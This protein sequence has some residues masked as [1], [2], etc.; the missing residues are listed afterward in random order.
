[1]ST[2]TLEYADGEITKNTELDVT[3]TNI[4][5]SW[6][7][8]AVTLAEDWKIYKDD[9]YSIIDS[10]QS[11]STHTSSNENGV[12][13]LKSNVYELPQGAA[14]N[15]T[16]SSNIDL[17][18]EFSKETKGYLILK[19]TKPDGKIAQE[20]IRMS[21]NVNSFHYQYVIKSD[22]P[23]GEYKI[24]VSA[25]PSGIQLEPLSFTVIAANP[26]NQI[27]GGSGWENLEKYGGDVNAQSI[28][29]IV[30]HGKSSAPHLYI[31]VV[32]PG[33]NLLYSLIISE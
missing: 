24:T 26:E 15:L 3:A 19:V 13:R 20:D 11:T 4:D 8:S 31:D 22:F 32:L 30:S 33:D 28:S 21:R 1:L 10:I 6:V 12:L 5:S 9:I 17:F 23:T 7:I 2:Y 29:F 14:T 25:E 27:C 18:G 16:Y